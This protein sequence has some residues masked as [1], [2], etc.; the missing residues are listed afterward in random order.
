MTD[1]LSRR[2]ES[3][4]WQVAPTENYAQYLALDRLLSA[5]R[6]RSGVHDEMLFIIIHQTQELWMKLFL[7]E[8]RAAMK[9]IQADHLE[10]VL[11]IL[12]R[13][14][15]VQIQL[16]Q[17]W[18]VLST[19]TPLDYENLQPHLGTGS[20]IQSFQYRL[21]E[22]TLGNKDAALIEVH[23]ADHEHYISLQ[24]ALNQPSLYDETLRLLALRGFAVPCEVV[25]RCWSTPYRANAAVEAAWLEVYQDVETHWDLYDL[26][27]KLVDLEDRFQQW[28]FRH[29]KTVE[30]IIGR[31]SGTG[32]SSGVPYLAKA[33]DLKLFPELWSVR[34]AL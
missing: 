22:F 16:M 20:G 3:I 29:L 21:L 4:H 34:T 10:P 12:S 27:E 17:S 30:R 23:K 19:L 28:R 5:Q 2:E 8:I 9:G 25:E 31:K 33:L 11:K 7:H 32:G 13:T 1:P 15:R 14:A 24:Q 6:P 18:D 26:A